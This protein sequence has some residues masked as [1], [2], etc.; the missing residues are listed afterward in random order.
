MKQ[1]AIYYTRRVRDDGTVYYQDKLGSDGIAILDG[2]YGRAK[3]DQQAREIGNRRKAFGI[4]GYRLARGS[5]LDRLFFLT[6]A[7]QPL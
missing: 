1:W 5:R 6:A 2:R 3:R 4:D 7:I